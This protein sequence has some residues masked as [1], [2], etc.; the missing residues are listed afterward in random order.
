MNLNPYYNQL[1][2]LLKIGT[3]MNRSERKDIDISNL[4]KGGSVK[5]DDTVYLVTNKHRYEQ[6][7]DG[8]TYTWYEYEIEDVITGDKRFLEYEDD[9]GIEVTITES[10]YNMNSLGITPKFL[11]D[12]DDDEEGCIDIDGTE[13][14][15][16]D[17]D[18]AKFFKNN[19]TEG[20]DLY[21]WEFEDS[22]GDNYFAFEKW[23]KKEYACCSGSYVDTNN[24]M[25]ILN[26]GENLNA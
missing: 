6:K 24:G 17:S 25:T 5:I 19:G 20:T 26:T 4:E 18:K 15:Y 16:E 10:F 8:I 2:R 7:E 13:Y 14:Y 11:K 9:D 1:D 21:Y 22:A 23:G 12:V 3:V